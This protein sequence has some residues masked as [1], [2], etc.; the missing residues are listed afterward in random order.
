MAEVFD[1]VW[2]SRKLGCDLEDWVP[3]KYTN[4]VPELPLG[5][6]PHD[7]YPPT[8]FGNVVPFNRPIQKKHR[9]NPAS[10]KVAKPDR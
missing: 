3:Q 1:R 4:L 8:P 7:V 10:D 2:A 6:I 9:V 5:N